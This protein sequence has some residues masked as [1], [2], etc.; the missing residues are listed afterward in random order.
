VLHI[1]GYSSLLLIEAVSVGASITA[2]SGSAAM[3]ALIVGLLGSMPTANRL[4]G[5]LFERVTRG[6]DWSESA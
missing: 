4:A 6:S 2:H 3:A 5:H 1:L